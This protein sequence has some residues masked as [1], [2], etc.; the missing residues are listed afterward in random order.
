MSITDDTIPWT[1]GFAE[2]GA[3]IKELER[4]NAALAKD[5]DKWLIMAGD[6][7]DLLRSTHE[8]IAPS[9]YA[10]EKLSQYDAGA[11]ARDAQS[12]DLLALAPLPVEKTQE[13]LDAEF[14]QK[15]ETENG[16]WSEW[17]AKAIAYGRAT[18]A[19]ET[20]K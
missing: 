8:I 14:I 2:R 4:E 16:T 19:K 11:A 6:L 13:E 18:A 1:D 9:S 17:I 5:R 3:R 20:S 7:A 15:A 10:K 12:A